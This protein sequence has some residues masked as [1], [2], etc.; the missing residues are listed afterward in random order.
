MVGTMHCG[1]SGNCLPS[2]LPSVLPVSHSIAVVVGACALGDAG[3]LVQ[4]GHGHHQHALA[5]GDEHEFL[6]GF[7]VLLFTHGLGNGYLVL[8]G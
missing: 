3:Q 2:F 8:A 6:P 1:L 7:P 5:L 4:L